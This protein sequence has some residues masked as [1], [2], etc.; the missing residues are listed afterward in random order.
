M[1]TATVERT[2]AH[3]RPAETFAGIPLTRLVG[4]ELRKMFDTRAGFWLM[5]SIAL[6]A[7][8][9]TAAVIA[10]APDEAMSYDTFGAALGVPMTVVL[11]IIAILSVTSE[12]SQRSGLT[13]FTLSPRR[14]R[15]I[16][17]KGL[18][19]ALVGV[20]GALVALGIGALGNLL[21]AAIT[22][23]DPVWN[24]TAA[25]FAQI[26]LAM[27][28]SMAIGFMLG[29]L[30]RS[31]AAAIVGYF[32]YAFVLPGLF[33]ILAAFQEWFRDLQPWVDFQLAT[34]RLYDTTLTSE[35]WAQLGVT[36]LLWLALP[37]TIG[38]VMTLRS[39]IK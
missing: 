28:L 11:P 12:W 8:A 9:A 39:E 30:I 10:W 7:T 21:G 36:G 16:L 37:L 29:L 32:V 34:S 22:G 25:S 23:V 14:G 13:T 15:V 5:A 35:H 24:V 17:A 27:C 20:V 6:V 18:G 3:A 31:S 33:G 26:T 2:A 1:S 38:T 19:V 4:I